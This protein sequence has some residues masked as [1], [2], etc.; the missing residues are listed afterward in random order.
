MMTSEGFLLHLVLVQQ[1]FLLKGRWTARCIVC[2]HNC[3]LLIRL[4]SS[5]CVGVCSFSIRLPDAG[6]T[7]HDQK[8]RRKFSAGYGGCFDVAVSFN[9]LSVDCD[10]RNFT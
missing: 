1:Q 3:Y 6:V 5:V 2:A 7:R 8:K 4:M 10:W 9:V